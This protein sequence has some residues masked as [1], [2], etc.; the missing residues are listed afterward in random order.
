MTYFDLLPITFYIIAF[1]DFFYF[2]LA[3]LTL[4]TLMTNYGLNNTNNVVVTSVFIV[5]C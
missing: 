4:N 5:K 1:V 3:N 2:L